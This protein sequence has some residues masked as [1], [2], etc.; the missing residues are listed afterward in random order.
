MASPIRLLLP[1][2]AFFPAPRWAAPFC[3]SGPVIELTLGNCSVRV[4]DQSDVQSWGFPVDIEGADSLCVV[5]STVVANTFIM[6]AN[7]CNDSNLINL[8]GLKLTPEQCRSRRG[9][10]VTEEEAKKLPFAS[11][12]G[13]A[14]ANPNWEKLGNRIDA[15]AH[16]TLRFLDDTVSMVVGFLSVGQKS[17]ASHLGLAL[18]SV[19]LQ[20]LK[21]QD[22]I[23]AR[24][25]SI[26]AGS[27]SI[28]FPR[29]GSLVLGGYD[30][31]SYVASSYRE[32]PVN[33][34]RVGERYCPLQV[35]VTQINMTGIRVDP[36]TGEEH[37]ISSVILTRSSNTPFC[38]EPYDNLFRL[39]STKP[40]T[41]WFADV[42]GWNDGLATVK[43]YSSKLVD[44]EPGLV[45]SSKAPSFDGSMTIEVSGDMVV[46]IPLYELWRPLRG[47]DAHGTYQLNNNYTELQIYAAEGEGDAAVLG[48]A[49]LSQVYLFVDYDATPPIFR[50]TPRGEG[51]VPT[52]AV[53][54][55][56]C[57]AEGLRPADKGLIGVGSVL[58][59]LILGLVGYAVYRCYPWAGA[60]K[61]QGGEGSPPPELAR[62]Q[63]KAA[64]N[65]TPPDGKGNGSGGAA[66]TTGSRGVEKR[67]AV[68]STNPAINDRA[69][70]T[71]ASIN[72][73]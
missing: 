19:L 59:A 28:Q 11:T 4:A 50:L 18:G 48:K 23:A 64:T 69:A 15:A 1:F 29:R 3:A 27:Q 56:P 34:G 58:G 7:I 10:F 14:D 44:L 67:R 12:D 8:D 35:P 16:A 13:L 40:V 26:D 37:T 57:P 45:F 25:F 36:R 32:Y 22:L 47:L 46:E 55:A 70:S 21:D 17:T 72:I 66:A 42:T 33:S 54:S 31:A 68:A 62:E 41:D 30:R 9:G 63:G 60:G 73:R 39:P 43:E 51:V 71:N 65:Q 52:G 61:G 20:T 6:T 49:F 24:S 5:P 2:L 38:L 53:S